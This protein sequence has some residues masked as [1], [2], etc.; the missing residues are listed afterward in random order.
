VE[1]ILALVK[2]KIISF[3]LRFNVIIGKK[4]SFWMAQHEADDY[5]IKNEKFDLRTIPRRIKNLLL[6]DEDIIERRRAICNDCEFRFGLN[7]K[8]CGCFI[9][10]KT[11]VAGQSCPVGK[12]DKVIIEDKKVGSVATA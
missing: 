9:D 6:H 7:C 11:K 1:K 4:L 5:V 8:K 10:A 12:W 3:L 2:Y